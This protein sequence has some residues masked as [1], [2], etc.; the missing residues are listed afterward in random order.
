[1]RNRRLR[2]ALVLVLL[3]SAPCLL[4]LLQV[5]LYAG[6]L[7][8]FDQWETPGRLLV[9]HVRGDLTW[10]DFFA[11]HNEARKAFSGALWFS[12]A[13]DGW[14][15]REEMVLAVLLVYAGVAC[16]YLVARKVFT[17]R[18][19]AQVAV[20]AAASVIL[21]NPYGLSGAW[22]WGVNLEN[23]IVVFTLLLGVVANLYI[24]NGS[25]RYSTVATLSACA[26]FTFPNGLALWIF[27]LPRWYRGA[28]GGGPSRPTEPRALELGYIA[29]FV[30]VVAFYF[31]GYTTPAHHTSLRDAL[32]A[33]IRFV[34]FYTAWLGGPLTTHLRSSLPASAF[35]AC[36]LL[37]WA[38]CVGIVVRHRAWGETA[39][40][41]ALTAYSLVS[42]AAVAVGRSP[43]GPWSALAA[44]YVLHVVVF[45]VGLGGLLAW[46]AGRRPTDRRRR[47][48]LAVVFALFSIPVV[49]V[50]LQWRD[51]YPR[52]I[53]KFRELITRCE[54]ALRFVDLIPDNPEL[55]GM[56]GNP[57]Y[58]VPT[59]RSLL[60]AG[61]LK[62]ETVPG[63][64]ALTESATALGL[65]AGLQLEIEGRELFVR[66]TL[67]GSKE[68]SQLTHLLVYCEDE[69]RFV[70]VLQLGVF[71]RWLDAESRQVDAALN[72]DHLAN[73]VHRLRLFGYDMLRRLLVPT[74]VRL[75]MRQLR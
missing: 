44:R 19:G 29:L 1:M 9:K 53:R 8:Y 37:V 62:F 10:S 42:G 32:A 30:A 5:H 58:L 54:T 60:S 73:G 57:A 34:Q 59:F 28:T 51:V 56:N 38:L 40:W 75:E 50:A 45:Y 26:S 24:R 47:V 27:L 13:V 55:G 71:A 23:A 14:S 17:E 25:L 16:V 69:E 35:G 12:M 52:H 6:E 61:I 7:P 70:T 43:L 39:P 66:G 36:A 64:E 68:A 48:P 15:V 11:Q 18:Y 72:L 74:D 65:S 20:T 49:A 41:L 4:L 33:P 2:R 46:A 67:G 22:L 31:H 63:R 21:F 3:T